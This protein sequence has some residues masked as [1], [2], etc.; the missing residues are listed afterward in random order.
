MS[1]INALQDFNTGTYCAVLNSEG[2]VL[3]GIGDMDINAQITP[4]MVGGELG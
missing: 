3:F 2:Q 1:A 4:S